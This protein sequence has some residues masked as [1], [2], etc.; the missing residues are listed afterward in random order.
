MAREIWFKR[1][2]WSYVPCHWKGFGVIAA[3]ATPTV[4]GFFAGEMALDALGREDLVR[5][6]FPTVFLP[7]L[8]AGLVVAK[9]H[10]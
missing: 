1:V 8:I 5:V 7:A 10:S 3:V 6:V 4:A 9:R 2:M